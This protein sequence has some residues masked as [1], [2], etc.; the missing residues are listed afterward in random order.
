MRGEKSST[1]RSLLLARWRKGG[2]EPPAPPARQTT[3]LPE[4]APSARRADEATLF[5]DFEAELT[6]A[7]A[8]PMARTLCGMLQD[9]KTAWQAARTPENRVKVLSALDHLEDILDAVL[10]TVAARSSEAGTGGEP[11]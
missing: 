1:S 5:R 6:A 10:L 11:S 9:S 3:V 2:S 7:V 8:E 4:P